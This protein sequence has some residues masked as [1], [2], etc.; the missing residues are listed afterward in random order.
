MDERHS[1]ENRMMY[2]PLPQRPLGHDSITLG[3]QGGL[4]RGMAFGS[5]PSTYASRMA[6]ISSPGDEHRVGPGLNGFSSIPEPAA[7]GQ[8]EDPMPTYVSE[9]FVAPSGYDQLVKGMLHMGRE[10]QIA[11]MNLC[12]HS[13]FNI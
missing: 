7:Y 3:P 9:R 1:Y 5:Q 2:I 12:L 4:V 13:V 6:E 11:L 10:T 8:R